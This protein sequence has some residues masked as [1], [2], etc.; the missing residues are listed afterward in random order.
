MYKALN[1][2]V[3]AIFGGQKYHLKRTKVS[4]RLRASKSPKSRGFGRKSGQKYHRFL[5]ILNPL[6]G[7]LRGARVFLENPPLE[8]KKQND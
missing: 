2:G 1:L 7:V 3:F 6:K 8:E 5:K 4:P